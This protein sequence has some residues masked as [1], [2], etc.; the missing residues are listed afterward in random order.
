MAV[1]LVL[2]AAVISA[3]KKQLVSIYETL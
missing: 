1:K 3:A 2:L